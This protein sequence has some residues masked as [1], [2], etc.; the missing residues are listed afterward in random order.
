MK[1]KL[2]TGKQIVWLLT[3]EIK[4]GGSYTFPAMGFSFFRTPDFNNQ[5]YID[6]NP[7]TRSLASERFKVKEIK[8]GFCRG[9]FAFKPKGPD[10]WLLES[11]LEMRG[12]FESLFLL[13]VCFIP[14]LIKNIIRQKYSHETINN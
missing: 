2:L 5:E 8:N 1:M 3:R 7:F 10:M 9:N 6:T 11:D 12:L 13:I 14:F 4:I